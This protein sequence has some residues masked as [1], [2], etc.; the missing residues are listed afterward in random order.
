MSKTLVLFDF[1][2]TLTKRDTFPQFIF[3]SQGYLKGLCGFLV[4]SPMVLL[5][6]LKVVSGARLKEKV[7]AYF[8]KSIN[9]DELKIKGKFFIE[10]L[11]ATDG[12][13]DPVMK[14]L[15]NYKAA[16]VEVCIVSASLDIWIEP[17]CKQFNLNYLCTELGYENGICSG[18]FKT[19]NCNNN[20]KAVRIRQK[21]NL[22]DFSKIVA[23]GNSNGDKEMFELATETILIRN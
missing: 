19:P 14:S 7:A 23:Y 8:F 13:N 16:G 1:D 10:N 17:F 21:Y 2:G 4:F 12:F 18:T 20:E 3:F 5:F 22:N 11:S 9:Q 15:Q 6:F